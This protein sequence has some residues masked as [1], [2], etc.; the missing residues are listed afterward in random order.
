MIKQVFPGIT[1]LRSRVNLNRV[2][3]V[4]TV[5][6]DGRFVTVVLDNGETLTESELFAHWLRGE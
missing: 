5:K 4:V 6:R 2:R 1:K 3:T